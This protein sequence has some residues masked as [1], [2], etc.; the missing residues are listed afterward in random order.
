MK[1]IKT[2]DSAK[3]V[4]ALTARLKNELGKSKKVLWL[5]SGGSAVTAEVEILSAL[6]KSTKIEN[7]A[8]MLMDERYGPAGHADSNWQQLLEA[9]ADFSGL[10]AL[11]VMGAE[12]KSFEETVSEYAR[13]T[14]TALDGADV[15]VGLFGMGPDGHTAG[16]LPNTT[17]VQKTE[18]L[19]VGY[20]SAPYMR[21]S[22]TRK[23]LQ[24]VDVA[25]VFAFGDPKNKALSVLQAR[26]KTFV[27]LPS[28]L[29]WD[30]PEA[31]VYNDQVGEAA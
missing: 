24:R 22:L 21:I 16:L 15:V 23:A 17:A 31:Y 28:K 4:K 13:L 10:Y 5:L 18:Q 6:H 26:K 8:V 25:Y 9:G 3:G 11:P 1:F 7:L 30:V 12:A 2:S 19:V 29:L 14:S 20:K 27:T